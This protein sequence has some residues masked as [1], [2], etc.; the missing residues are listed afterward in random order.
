MSGNG[1][2]DTWRMARCAGATEITWE[3][4]PHDDTYM[5]RFIWGAAFAENRFYCQV[6]VTKYEVLTAPSVRELEDR[7]VYNAIKFVE[8]NPD[9]PG[10]VREAIHRAERISNWPRRGTG[11]REAMELMERYAGDAFIKHKARNKL[12]SQQCVPVDDSYPPD[13]TQEE[14]INNTLVLV[15][16]EGDILV[17]MV[18]RTG[19][20]GWVVEGAIGQLIEE[21]WVRARIFAVHVVTC[22]KEHT[23]TA[24][25]MRHVSSNM[26]VT[27]NDDMTEYIIKGGGNMWQSTEDQSQRLTPHMLQNAANQI[28]TASNVGSVVPWKE[29]VF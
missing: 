26:V 24:Y 2:L 8:K 25:D 12:L 1:G 19:S 5:Y 3:W 23:M 22:G 28:R 29:F 6:V 18:Y 21:F 16:V 27:L 9:T 13:M 10:M 17:P 7:I 14:R 20:S 11:Y 15:R 4:L